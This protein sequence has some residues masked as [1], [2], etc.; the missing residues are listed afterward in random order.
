MFSPLSVSKDLPISSPHVS[1]SD[2]LNYLAKG[3]INGPLLMFTNGFDS[4]SFPVFVSDLTPC[5]SRNNIYTINTVAKPVSGD[6]SD[7]VDVMFVVLP[8]S[9]NLD[10]RVSKWVRD[11]ADGIFKVEKVYQGATKLSD[12]YSQ[13]RPTSFIYKVQSGTVTGTQFAVQ[14]TLSSVIS[15]D[16]LQ[17]STVDYQ[18]LTSFAYNTFAAATQATVIEGHVCSAPPY[19]SFNMK[20]VQDK[21]VYQTS[22]S[23]RTISYAGLNGAGGL[24]QPG[25]TGFNPPP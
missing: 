6:T 18:S 5:S 20:E 3:R 22:P 14:G 9:M 11:P 15:L 16:G 19:G 25:W 7:S 23:S 13:A 10:A 21:T 1:S 17:I 12:F 2:I 4:G 24:I 8:Y